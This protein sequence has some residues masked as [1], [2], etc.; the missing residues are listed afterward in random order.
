MVLTD[1][2]CSSGALMPDESL[3][4]TSGFNDRER[5][6][7]VFD[8]SC[9]KCDWKEILSGLVN[10]R[11]YATNHVLPDGHQIVIGGRRQ[12]NYEFYPKTMSS[13][14]AYNLAFLA[15]TN[16]PVIEN[17]LYPF[18]FLNT[19]GNLFTSA[20]NRAILFDYSR[21]QV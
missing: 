3:V 7:R 8:K 15:Q 4:Q 9:C 2:W 13:D 5:V 18:G 1:V 16:D 17:N 11:W 12:F 14:K 19:D 10:Q 6:V 21:N 20:N